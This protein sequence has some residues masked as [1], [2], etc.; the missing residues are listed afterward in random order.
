MDE[1]LE[2]LMD[3]L[4]ALK[5]EE[6]DAAAILLLL[7]TPEMQDEL[8]DWILQTYHQNRDLLTTQNVIRKAWQ[9]GGLIGE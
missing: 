3:L 2:D 9:I 7:K 4:K 1:T 5:V 6:D 8:I